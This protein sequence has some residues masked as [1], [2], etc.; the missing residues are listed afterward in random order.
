MGF[1][2]FY[3]IH[4]KISTLCLLYLLFAVGHVLAQGAFCDQFH[5]KSPTS[6][7]IFQSGERE[8]KK[9]DKEL[10]FIVI[11]LISRKEAPAQL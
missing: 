9:A 4:V 2:T 7:L 11:L 6:A 8:R 10:D 1:I 3:V 5:Y